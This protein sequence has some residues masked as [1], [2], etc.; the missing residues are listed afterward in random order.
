VRSVQVF[1]VSEENEGREQ[2]VVFMREVLLKKT[3]TFTIFFKKR[4][5]RERRFSP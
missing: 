2:K 1:S 5:K 4:K 3:N